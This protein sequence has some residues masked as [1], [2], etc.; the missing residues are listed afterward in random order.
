MLLTGNWLL[1]MPTTDV[2]RYMAML[3]ILL[4]CLHLDNTQCGIRIEEKEI[5]WSQRNR[6]NKNKQQCRHQFCTHP[7][8]LSESVPCSLCNWS[9]YD[10]VG[11]HYNQMLMIHSFEGNYLLCMEH[12]R[13]NLSVRYEFIAMS[14]VSH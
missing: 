2:L 11:T 14:G 8:L 10:I 13:N 4:S 3:K 6:G 9:Q 7:S 1:F 12:V 5:T